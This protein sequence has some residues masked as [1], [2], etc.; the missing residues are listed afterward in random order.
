MSPGTRLR[1]AVVGGG[2][3]GMAAARDLARHH[4]VTLFE[5]GARLGGH[6]H[7][8]EVDDGAG[9]SLWV[10][11]AFLIYNARHY[12]RFCQMLRELGVDAQTQRADMSASF[13]DDDANMRF[14]LLRGASGFAAQ[15]RNF[16][17]P[18]F[19]RMF[20]EL[21]LLRR[22]ARRDLQARR[23]A[24]SATIDEYL[25]GYSA[26]FRHQLVYPLAS[27]IWSLPGRHIAQYPALAILGFFE[28]HGLLGGHSGDAWR[29]FVGGSGV[30]VD[31]FRR[32]FPGT[33][34]VGTP[35]RKVRRVGGTVQLSLG[36]GTAVFDRVVLATHADRSLGMLGDASEQERRVLGAFSYNET[37]IALHRDPRVVHLDRRLWASWNATTRGG[38]TR[39]TYYLNRV[40]SLPTPRD[41][42]L[43]LDA[44][45]DDAEIAPHLRERTFSYRHPIFD[46]A[47]VAAQRDLPA[48]NARPGALTFFAGAYAGHGF[49]EDGVVAGQAAAAALER[50]VFARTMELPTLQ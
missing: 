23:I 46:A 7:A 3:S 18:A 27:A 10:D 6:A 17:R 44:E 11:T 24:P 20:A 48:L 4:D 21:L 19:Y 40:Q 5:A 8:V 36:D 9:K 14:A 35:A 1:V 28:N 50:T 39:I 42:F 45:D 15:K 47:A 32:A 38:R 16:V 34:H 22:R 33:V 25:A 49:H 12:P 37:R 41:W 31:A 26:P 13:V 30:Y 29:T 43:T 2:I